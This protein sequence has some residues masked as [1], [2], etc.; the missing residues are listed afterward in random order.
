M[1]MADGLRAADLV[2][3]RA[4]GTLSELCAAGTPAIVVPSPYVAENHQEKNARIL[5]QAGAVKVITEPE[6]TPEL[7]YDTAWSLLQAPD[8]L[9]EM[10]KNARAKAQPDVLENIYQ[11]LKNL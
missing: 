9:A 3:C 2:I 10:G 8:T 7:L 4:G 11:T 5:E 1:D 6:S